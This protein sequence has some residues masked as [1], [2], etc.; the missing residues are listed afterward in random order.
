MRANLQHRSCRATA[1]RSVGRLQ[2]SRVSVRPVANMALPSDFKDSY[3]DLAH[4]L[5]DAAAQV[6]RKYFRTSFDVES[7]GDTSPVTIADRQAEIA[8]REM[9][10]RTFPEHGIF[11]EE[12]GLKFGSGAGSKYMWVLDPIDGTKSF[13]TGKPLFGTLISLVYEGSPVL[14]IIDQPITKERWVGVVGRPTTLNGQQ[15]RTRTC[16]DVKLAYLYATTPH[17]FSGDNEVAFNRL[18]DSVRIPMYGC[19]CYAYGLLAAGHC[20]LVVEA[21]LKPYDYMALVPVVQGAGG[22]MSDWRGRPLVWQPSPGATD[23]KA[24][25][26]GEVCAAG[27]PQLHRRALELLDWK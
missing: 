22:V 4:Q 9:I 26:P 25:W 3:V 1:G 20:D 10:E 12:H 6:T 8:M 2:R 16:P 17:M 19:D 23:L 27:D 11:G 7:K 24:G 21:D 13:I 18:R 14:G 15:L 5:A